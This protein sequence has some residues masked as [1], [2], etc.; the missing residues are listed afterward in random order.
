MARKRDMKHYTDVNLTRGSI[1]Y[2]A[3]C[4]YRETISIVLKTFLCGEK[5][6]ANICQ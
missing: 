5:I 1:P 3:T 4:K 6:F 2:L